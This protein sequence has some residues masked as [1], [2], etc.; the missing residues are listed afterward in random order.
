[1]VLEQMIAG[2]SDGEDAAGAALDPEVLPPLP[3]AE[4]IV[5][6]PAEP[7]LPVG[8]VSAV[9]EGMLVVQVGPGLAVQVCGALSRLHRRQLVVIRHGIQSA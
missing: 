8:S 1:V 9:V 5:I 4:E 6:D 2:A 7:L 3:A